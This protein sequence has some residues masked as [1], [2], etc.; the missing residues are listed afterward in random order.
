MKTLFKNRIE[1]LCLIL[2]MG[3]AGKGTT[4][5][6]VGGAPQAFTLPTIP[7][8]LTEVGDRANYLVEH[9]WD[10]FDFGDTTSVHL[11]EITEQ[12]F[13]D[14][15]DVLPH[16]EPSVAATSIQNLLTEAEVEPTGAMLRYFLELA[17]KYL[18]DPN[19]PMRNENMYIP[20]AQY[21]VESTS[22][23]LTIAEKE[24][25]KYRLTMMQKNRVGTQ[26]ADFTYHTQP[27]GTRGTLHTIK[28]EYTLVLFYNPE[29]HTCTT[30][31]SALK[32]LDILGSLQR[33]GRLKV[34][35]FYPDN[36]LAL[37]TK[38]MPEIPSTWLNGYDKNLVVETARLYDLKAIPTI[39]LLDKQKTVILKDA[40]VEQVA[41]FLTQL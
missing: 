20:V 35:A 29:C 14:Y 12:A 37:W 40:P 3:C 39:Y 31:I 10:N 25:A 30:I 21:L 17:S 9:Y 23:L 8:V 16:A 15:I 36:K 7:D 32:D 13:V 26:A 34:L 6:G 24:P 41:Q 1:L 28:S 5:G 22:P 18:Y 19:S 4:Q 33:S 27:P 38:K 2:L 11:P